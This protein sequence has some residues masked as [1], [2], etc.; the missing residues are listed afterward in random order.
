MAKMRMSHNLMKATVESVFH[1]HFAG[2]LELVDEMRSKPT[3]SLKT[4]TCLEGQ[5]DGMILWGKVRM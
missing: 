3:I 4:T 5:G 2:K 1:C